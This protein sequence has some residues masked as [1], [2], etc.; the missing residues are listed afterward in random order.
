MMR[1]EKRDIMMEVIRLFGNAPNTLRIRRMP[2]KVGM[3]LSLFWRRRLDSLGMVRV[4]RQVV[5]ESIGLN[6]GG[7]SWDST[8]GC[9]RCSVVVQMPM[10]DDSQC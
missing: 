4:D 5:M 3:N 9:W 8:W 7:K 1:V 6:E 2:R 10:G